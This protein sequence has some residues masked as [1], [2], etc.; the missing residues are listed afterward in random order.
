MNY[1]NEIVVLLVSLLLLACAS[2]QKIQPEIKEILVTKIKENGIKLF[3][4][5]VTMSSLQKG[6][7]GR[8]A[9]RG[10]PGGMGGDMQGKNGAGRPDRESMMKRMKEKKKEKINRKL[11]YKLAETGYCRE[12][13]IEL[14]SYVGRGQSQIKRE[15]KESATDS[16]RKRF[17]NAVNI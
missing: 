4:Y 3:S 15:C 2:D 10:M 16:D 13:Y 12:G 17:A 6:M 8:G 14:D 1:K 5:S 9:G 7:D 11:D